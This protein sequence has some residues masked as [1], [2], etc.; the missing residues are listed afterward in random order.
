MIA[1]LARLRLSDAEIQTMTRDLGSILEYVNQLAKV[2]TA[3]VEPLA[4]PLHMAYGAA[5][6][7]F[8]DRG[9]GGGH[10]QRRTPERA[11]D[12]DLLGRLAE[13]VVAGNGRQRIAVGDR[14]GIGREVGP[15]AERLPAAAEIGRVSGIDPERVAQALADLKGDRHAS[16]GID[17]AADL[18]ADRGK[19]PEARQQ[20]V[21]RPLP[22]PNA[23]AISALPKCMRPVPMSMMIRP[24]F[25]GLPMNTN[26]CEIAACA[27]GSFEE[28]TSSSSNLASAP[29]APSTAT[30]THRSA[31]MS[32][33]L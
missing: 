18:N 4:H 20:I 8:G 1:H 2:D 14:L 29:N 28:T 15:H 22:L 25:A 6:A 16:R 17:G 30:A 11:G 27:S 10:R 24:P 9:E 21:A 5:V 26:P 31:L 7:D 12:E 33:P 3:G 19:H 32:V 23:P 13:A